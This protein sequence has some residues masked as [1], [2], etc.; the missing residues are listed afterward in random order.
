M[1]S[2]KGSILL[3]V[4]LWTIALRAQ[5]A[6]ELETF[7]SGFASPVDIA[8]P[9]DERLFIVE[10]EGYIRIVE[11]DGTV[12]ADDFLDIHNQIESGYQEQGLLGL[13]FHPDF[14]SNGYF[15]VYYTDLDGNTVV[16]R[17]SVS[18]GDP[19]VAD[20]GSEMIMLT[21]VQPFLNHNG[22]CMKFGGDGYLY[23]GLGDGGSAGDPG[24][25]AQN[26]ELFLGKILRIDV[27][28]GTPYGIPAD[29]PYATATDTL[30][31]IWAF[32]VRNPWRFT[33][34]KL[35]KNLWIGDVGQNL[36][37]EID[38]ELAGDGGHDYGW[39]CYEGNHEFNTTGCDGDTAYTFPIM[40]YNHNAT[41]GG[42]SVTGG[43]VYRG[44]A[45]P[46]M[47]GYYL[48]ADYVSGNW[49]WIHADGGAPYTNLRLDDIQTSISCFGEDIYGELYCANLSSGVINH[50]KDAC[51]DFMPSAVVT[52]YT[53]GVENGAVDITITAGTAPFTFDW[54]SG[55]TTE[56]IT[57]IT[58]PG[59]YTLTVEDAAGCSRSIT[60]T[61]NDIPPF[62][63]TLN[64]D[65]GV[66]TATPGTSWQWYLDGE[67]IAGA[68]EQSYTPSSSG[69]YSCM[70]TDANGCSVMTPEF[71][72]F[73]GI[74]NEQWHIAYSINPNPAT[75]NLNLQITGARIDS[76]WY[77]TDL[78]GNIV[79]QSDV[80]GQ[81]DHAIN[82]NIDSFPAGMYFM[83]SDVATSATQWLKVTE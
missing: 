15:Y 58:E 21:E 14:A 59:T 72:V 40:E 33:F 39:R 63:A 62:I 64:E 69:N 23:I 83:R 37:E 45:Y 73:V 50:I 71:N 34:D 68:T 26:P 54:S 44:T 47:Y 5:P 74:E 12:L 57:D 75:D 52:D 22:G 55:E 36:Y 66:L 53:C 49:W 76:H 81:G 4:S 2:L 9:G 24:N 78:M 80:I 46:G 82:I 30:P 43:F 28:G 6:I 25:R 20:A 41:T 11:L 7:A 67:I 51:G 8:T 16:S 13:A 18:A 60:V 3:F 38:M 27:D 10:R 77:I 17:F 1:P 70:V 65:A 48:A 56:D 32:G 19:N 35:T 42:F 29:N 31:E 61:I 79:W